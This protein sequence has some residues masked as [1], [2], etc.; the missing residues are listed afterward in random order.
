RR[1]SSRSSPA[2]SPTRRGPSAASGRR[3]TGSSGSA[4]C[5]PDE[6]DGWYAWSAGA[7]L[8]ED[9]MATIAARVPATRDAE[10]A[11]MAPKLLHSQLR[12][13]VR[14]LSRVAD[15]PEG[16]EHDDEARRDVAFGADGTRWTLRARLPLDEGALVEQALTAAR[17]AVFR[18]RHP[19]AD[20]RTVH[21]SGV[22]WADALVRTA[23]DALSHTAEGRPSEHYQVLLHLDVGDDTARLHVADAVPDS[24][25]RYLSCDAD[26]RLLIEKDGVLAAMS[27]KLRTVDRRMRAFIEERDG[28]CRVPGC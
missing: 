24:V 7:Q 18:E 12:H 20:E 14:Q 10:V 22:S 2:C 17:D 8:T 13:F 21:R 27:S 15:A 1:S 11:A 6:R 16:L 28:G 5:P 4:A 3:S 9:A 23:Q 25:R 26:A 19:D